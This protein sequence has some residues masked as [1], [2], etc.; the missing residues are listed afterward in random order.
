[1]STGGLAAEL[2]SVLAEVLT[3]EHVPV[4]SNVFDDLGADSMVMTR[5]CARLR[6]RD[7]LPS[8]SIR[9]VY[10][11]PTIAGMA[12]AAAPAAGSSATQAAPTVAAPP[13]TPVRHSTAG[14]LLTGALQLLTFLAYATGV[15]YVMDRVYTWILASNGPLDIYLR[16]VVAGGAAILAMCVLPIVAKWLLIGRWTEREIP[17]WSLRYF[18]FWLVKTLTRANP[19]VLVMVGSPLYTLYLRALGAKVGRNVVVL[20]RHLPVA[21]DLLTIG[22]GTVI[23]K[24]A[25]LLGYRAHAGRIQTGRVTLGRDVVV[26]EK[27]VLGIG[28]AMGDG[29]QLGHASSLH[30]GQAVPAGQSWHGS[31]AVPTTTDFRAV[32]ATRVRALRSLAYVTSQVVKLF[33]LYVPL[34]FGGMVLVLTQVPG[35]GEP[36]KPGATEH[37]DAQFYLNAVTESALVVVG[38]LLAGLLVVFTVPR[39]LAPFVRPDRVYPVHGWRYSLHRTITRLTNIRLFVYLFGD[40]SFIVGYLYVLGY[41][42]GKV[43]QTGSNFGSNLNQETPFLTSVGR[44]TVVADGLSVVNADFSNTSFRTSRVAIGADNFLGNNIAYP[45]G[46]RTGDDCLLATKVAVPIDGPLRQ[47]VGLL[48][49]P[50]FEIPRTVK[51]D[52]VLEIDATERRR[53][54]RRKNAHNLGT[55]ALALVVRW[56]HILGLL[57]LGLLALNQYADLGPAAFAGEMAA[58]VLFTMLWFVL[59]ERISTGFRRLRPKSCSIYDARFWRHERYWKLMVPPL[60]RM[61]AGTPFKNLLMRLLGVKIGRRVYDDGAA[62][63]ERTLTTIGDDCTLN[64]GSIIQCHSQEDGAFKSDHIVIGSGVTLGV[65]AFVHYGVTIGD[66][67]EIAPDSFVMKGEEIPAGSRWGGNPARELVEPPAGSTGTSLAVPPTGNRHRAA[68]GDRCVPPALSWGGDDDPGAERSGVAR[69]GRRSAGRHR[70]ARLQPASGRRARRAATT[71]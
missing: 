4:D 40:S 29:A 60:D 28:T 3:V 50:A 57:L 32:P 59:W 35:L 16:S 63:L 36:L 62:V 30:R 8:I 15:G 49:S 71:G 12:A 64:F 65:G 9:D 23:R 19:L 11:N 25:V 53:R 24:D 37:T 48:G 68:V 1:M 44:G 38:G 61:L 14:Y 26:G 39:L 43:E 58:T 33:A 7:D 46:G 2:A 52:R 56:G 27:S 55:M 45:V 69:R 54:L 13:V 18:R 31:P 20:T 41:R 47:G 66:G 21:T 70:R 22:A 17:I 42:L 6:K 10:A 51:R 67:A 34:V 5:F